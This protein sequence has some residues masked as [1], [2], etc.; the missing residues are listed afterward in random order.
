MSSVSPAPN[1]LRLQVVVAAETDAGQVADLRKFLHIT[2]DTNDV[3]AL[4]QE[5]NAKFKHLYPTE[6]Y[7]SHIIAKANVGPLKYWESRM[8]LA[9]TWTP[10]TNSSM[11]LRNEAQQE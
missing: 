9:V 6:Q 2:N 8:V 10:P 7:L 1:K 4:S 5:V 11:C 3:A